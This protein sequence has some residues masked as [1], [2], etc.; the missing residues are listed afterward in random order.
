MLK[1]SNYGHI[2]NYNTYMFIIIDYEM[3]IIFTLLVKVHSQWQDAN[4]QHFH[5]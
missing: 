2:Y 3:F 1:I 5:V 4:I